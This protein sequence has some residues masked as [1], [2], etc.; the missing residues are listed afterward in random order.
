V[1]AANTSLG[2]I[3]TDNKGRTLYLF[4]KDTGTKSTCSGACASNWPPYTASS[5][6]AAGSGVKA[7]A[8][9]L[10]KQADGSMQV[11]LAGHPLYY[12]AG[13]QSAGQMNGQGQDAF[14]AKWWAV[15]PSGTQVT[16]AAKS[17][18]GSSTTGGSGGGGYSY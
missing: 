13:D 14:G 11:E 17:S 10:V 18:G 8:I 6:P 4:A 9:T 15:A 3:V 16:A 5:K 2:T 1:T 7:G 12:Y